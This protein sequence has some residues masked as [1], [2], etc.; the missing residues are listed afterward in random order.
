VDRGDL[1]Q[2]TG[3][4]SDALAISELAAREVPAFAAPLSAIAFD[5][6]QATSMVAK[7]ILVFVCMIVTPPIEPLPGPHQN[8]DTCK[9]SEQRANASH[10]AAV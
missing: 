10:Q 5:E 3:V 7:A 1:C 9:V 4:K 6:M 8:F 2:A